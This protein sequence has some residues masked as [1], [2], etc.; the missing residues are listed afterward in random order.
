[1]TTAPWRSAAARLARR[2]TVWR[3]R[4]ERE[5]AARIAPQ[6]VGR[7]APDADWRTEKADFTS[8]SV[9]VVAV[10][11]PGSAR[12]FVVKVPST[13]QGAA[14]LRRQ[15]GVLADLRRDPR[16]GPLHRLMPRCVEQGEVDGRYY[17]VEEALSGVPAHAVMQ[18]RWSR[19]V[20][21]PAATRVIG[22]LHARTREEVRLDDATVHAWVHAPL[23]H[24]A[25]SSAGKYRADVYVDGIRRLRDEL[26]RSLAGRTVRSSWI[27]GD[28]WPGNLLT[29]RQGTDVTGVVDWDGASARQLPLHDL[30]H[31]HIFSRR[32]AS[33]VELGDVVVHA[34]HGGID[35]AIGVPVGQIATWLDDIPPRTAILLYWLRHIVL[36]FDMEGHHDNPRWL[37]AN[38]RHVLASV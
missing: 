28:F 35:E 22:E 25:A 1:M 13:E 4:A 5:W 16:L 9:A 20:F 30:F 27:H 36:F 3:H 21:L 37:G 18:R 34:L 14:R 6:L 10:F 7:V 38:V 8:T 23:R 11:S 26:D 2:R 29:S 31:L 12:R 32:L 15:A 24:L 33:G 17:C 19:E